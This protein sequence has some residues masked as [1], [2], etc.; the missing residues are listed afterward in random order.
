MSNQHELLRQRVARVQP[1]ILKLLAKS[2]QLSA[3]AIASE[4]VH[5][6]ECNEVYG[7]IYSAVGNLRKRGRL[8][9]TKIKYVAHICN[10]CG[11]TTKNHTVRLYK[12]L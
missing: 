7:V 5:N 6:K 9:W 3:E 1:F 4:L 12:L 8:A 2:G 11:M 10:C